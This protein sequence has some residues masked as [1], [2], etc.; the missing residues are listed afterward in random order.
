MNKAPHDIPFYQEFAQLDADMIRLPDEITI[1]RFRHLLETQGLS[2]QILATV[3]SKLI[4][5]GLVLKTGTVVNS[6]LIAVPSSTKNDTGE[7]DPEMHKAKKGN[8]WHFCM[9]AHFGVD[10]ES[11]LVHSGTTTAANANDVTQAHALLHSEEEVVLADSV[12]QVIEKSE[13]IQVHH[14]DVDWQ[15]AMMP[16]KRKAS[17]KSKP[18]TRCG[19]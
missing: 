17:N 12:Y 11:G 2:Q 18:S 3:N 1:L 7:R 4:D 13:T 9:K 14:P 16:D 8:Q 5:C 15:I 10:A 19:T 6:T